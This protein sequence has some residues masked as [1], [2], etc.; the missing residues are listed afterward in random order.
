MVKSLSCAGPCGERVGHAVAE[1]QGRKRRRLVETA[2]PQL[3][4][5]RPAVLADREIIAAR[6]GADIDAVV[7][8]VDFGQD[9]EAGSR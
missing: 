1:I 6:A 2:D 9:A 3:G 7:R 4:G 5:G 8:G